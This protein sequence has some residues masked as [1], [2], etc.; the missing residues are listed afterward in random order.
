MQQVLLS[1]DDAQLQIS[2]LICQAGF[3]GSGTSQCMRTH[4]TPIP[5]GLRGVACET[6]W[7]TVSNI[8][9]VTDQFMMYSEKCK[10]SHLELFWSM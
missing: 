1:D 4:Q 2:N 10:A 9:E 3:S 8:K 6:T 7:G 5:F